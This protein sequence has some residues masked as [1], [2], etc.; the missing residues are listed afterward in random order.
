MSTF[1]MGRCIGMA[2]RGLWKRK[3]IEACKEA[4]TYEPYYANII[5]TLAVIMEIRDAAAKQYKESGGEPVIKYTNKRGFENLVE[6][7]ALT[8]INK[9]NQ[10]ALAYWRDLGLTPAGFRK[11]SGEKFGAKSDDS[12]ESV[13]AGLGM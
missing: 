3:I 1:L 10:Q 2:K 8:I 13:L 4:G 6:N 11:L 12:L 9:Q 5:E 7:P